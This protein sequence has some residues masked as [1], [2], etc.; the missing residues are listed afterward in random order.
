MENATGRQTQ[1]SV[2]KEPPL[3]QPTVCFITSRR[4]PQG[5]VCFPH[6]TVAQRGVTN[7]R[8]TLIERKQNEMHFYKCKE[9]FDS[10]VG[11]TTGSTGGVRFPEEVRYFSLLLS[12]HTGS[13]AH[14]MGPTEL[15]LGSK[16]VGA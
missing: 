8:Q 5:E 4:R 3:N 15:S 7:S 2:R 9:N 14:P 11:I 16:T 6:N 10:S 13:G 12:V 1:M